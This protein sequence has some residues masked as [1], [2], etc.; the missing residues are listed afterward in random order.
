LRIW[1]EIIGSIKM[2][3]WH[4]DRPGLDLKHAFNF[5]FKSRQGILGDNDLNTNLWSIALEFF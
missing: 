1:V 5:F 4:D 2:A 3:G